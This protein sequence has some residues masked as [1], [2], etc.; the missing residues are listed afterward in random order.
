[1][2]ARAQRAIASQGQ[3]LAK[4]E[5]AGE[6]Q[7]DPRTQAGEDQRDPRTLSDA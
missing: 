7:R 1:V 6:D 3:P 5:Q 2:D 4:L